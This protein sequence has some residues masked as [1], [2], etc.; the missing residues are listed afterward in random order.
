VVGLDGNFPV[1]S[2]KCR[3]TLVTIGGRRAPEAGEVAFFW[4]RAAGSARER[5]TREG[6]KR[7]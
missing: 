4:L 7:F 5:R 2:A 6:R 3:G 1:I